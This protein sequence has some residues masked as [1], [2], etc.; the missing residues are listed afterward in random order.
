MAKNSLNK[1]L[2]VIA[3]IVGVIIV[4]VLVYAIIRGVVLCG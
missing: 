4:I 3:G 1:S 2:Q